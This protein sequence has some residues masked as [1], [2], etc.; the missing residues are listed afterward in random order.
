MAFSINLR[1]ENAISGGLNEDKMT[2]SFSFTIPVRKNIDETRFTE[3]FSYSIPVK[4][5][6]ESKKM[7]AKED[8]KV[9][10]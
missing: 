8:N 7:D 1:N 3:K 10:K 9:D 2:E 5:E 4:T 6:A